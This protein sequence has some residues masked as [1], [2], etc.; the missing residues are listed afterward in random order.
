MSRSSSRPRP[1]RPC[2]TRRPSTTR[3]TRSA[4]ASRFRSARS[5]F[6]CLHSLATRGVRTNVTCMMSFNQAYLAALAGATYIS[7]FAG[8]VRDMGYDIRPIIQETRNILDREKLESKIIVGSIR[9]MMERQRRL[10]VRGRT[11][12]PCRPPSCARCC[13]TRAPTRPSASSTPLGPTAVRK[14]SGRDRRR[15]LRSSSRARTSRAEVTRAR[16]ISGA[17]RRCRWRLPVTAG[18]TSRCSTTM[19][20]GGCAPDRTS[21]SPAL[22][23]DTTPRAAERRR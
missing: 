13:G 7:I 3:G 9:H 1:R 19:A 8:R 14:P 18:N 15:S 16:G 4:S 10:A 2:S 12:S 21:A 5:G 22:R 11:S 6:A 20:L 17:C 23:R